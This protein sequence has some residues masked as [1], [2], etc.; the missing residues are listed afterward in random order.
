MSTLA[1]RAELVKLGRMLELEPEALTFLGDVPA[2]QL[3]NL[4][5]AVH[6]LLF[7][8]DRVAFQRLAAVAARLPVWL[9]VALCERPGPVLAARLT[10]EI[11]ARRAAQV[12]ARVSTAFAAD[13]CVHLDPRR[14]RDLI[15]QLPVERIVE[16]AQALVARRDFVTMSRF[17]DYLPDETIRTVAEAIEDEAALLRVAF[18]VGSK[19]RLDHLFRT[20]PRERL[21][22]MMLKV[23]E[24]AEELLPAFLSMLIHVSY[25]LKSELGDLA[26]AQGASVLAGYV[27]ATQE[28]GLWGEVLPVVAAMS[29]A[30]RRTVV[31]LP[32]LS[33][34]DVQ[35]S[36]VRAADEQ[37]LWGLV[38]P[39]VALMDDGNREAVAGIV[40]SRARDTLV[41]AADAA[42]MGE[43]WEPL[44]DLVRRMPPAQ[45]KEFGG[46]V[47]AF[48][49][50]DPELVGRIARRARAHGFEVALNGRASRAAG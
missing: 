4:R 15:R 48:G 16:V 45:R 13:V 36:I 50:V 17:V 47:A 20:L 38:L 39:L 28:L 41:K 23:E 6:E 14:G 49:D 1:S 42:L 8:Q 22:T 29:E 43:Q 9:S 10:A 3:R 7:Q 33:E 27:R 46:V 34:P 11:P 25:G 2:G 40:A 5:V 19:N 18:F 21:Q 26:A 44:L 37:G 30:S 12:G 24:E 32:V 35:E 31:N